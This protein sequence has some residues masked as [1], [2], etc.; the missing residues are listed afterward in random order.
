MPP[1]SDLIA[2]FQDG[3]FFG[4]IALGYSMVLEATGFFNFA[5]GAMVMFAAIFSAYLV[6]VIHMPLA[7]AVMVGIASAAILS[8]LSDQLVI[9]P[10]EKRGTGGELPALVAVTAVLFAIQQFAGTVFGRYPLPSESWINRPPLMWGSV[11][12]S[13]Q[14]IVT[15]VITLL[16][17]AAIHLWTKRSLYGRLLYAVGDNRNAARTLG[18]PV[19]RIRLVA[20]VLSGLIGGLAGTLFASNGGGVGFENGFSYS[21]YGFLALVIGGRGS[22]WAPLLGGLV[23][24]NAQTYSIYRF[25]GGA[26]DFA[27]LVLALIFFGLRPTGLVARRVRI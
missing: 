25:G 4:L 17:F 8:V 23:L 16:V 12:I 5:L 11:A 27:T 1:A 2:A 6:A 9:S 10:I 20:F 3:C 24:A 15:V 21:L 14:I 26:L 19:N 13:W 18:L 22:V 7:L